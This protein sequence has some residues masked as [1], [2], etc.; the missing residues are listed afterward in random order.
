MTSAPQLSGEVRDA[1]A[2]GQPVVALETTLVSHGFPGAQ[3]IQVALASEARVREQGA[4]P[5]TVGVLDGA[6]RVGLTEADLARFAEAGP[7]ARKVGA[8]DLAA[9]VVQGALGATTVG[10]T[11][12]VCRSAGIAFMATGGTGGV[13]RGFAATLDISADLP[14]IARTGALVVSSGVKSILDVPATAEL[15]ETLGVPVLGW[16]TSTLP[17]FYSPT[18][19]P[20]VSAVVTAAAEVARITAA[21]WLLNGS[22]GVLLTRPPEPSLDIEPILAEAVAQVDERGVRGQSVTPAVLALVHEMS[23]G[24]SAEVNQRLI[25][26]NAALA[27][28][29][30][31]AYSM[32]QQGR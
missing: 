31:V 7:Q 14:Q 27:A 23:E 11:L 2:A 22:T 9:C 15:L 24:R 26:D 30:A 12:A 25:A 20:P 5:A 16:R 19:G 21:H 8:R 13:H 29:V 10:G 28:E 4:V 6:V 32:E 3:G 17:M 18:G 1:L